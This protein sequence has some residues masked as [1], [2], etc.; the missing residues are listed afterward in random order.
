MPSGAREVGAR[1]TQAGQP[2]AQ[3]GIKHICIFKRFFISG[4][5]KGLVVLWGGEEGEI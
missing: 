2:G 1:P 5:K 4:V 3:G